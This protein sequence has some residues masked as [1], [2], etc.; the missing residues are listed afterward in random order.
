MER[1]LKDRLYDLKDWLQRKWCA[2]NG[3]RRGKPEEVCITNH[4]DGKEHHSE[5]VQCDYCGEVLKSLYSWTVPE[6]TQVIF[7]GAILPDE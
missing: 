4:Y 5:F 6:G 3:H 7:P 2:A 1:A